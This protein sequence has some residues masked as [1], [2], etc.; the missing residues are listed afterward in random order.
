[1]ITVAGQHLV[2]ERLKLTARDT[3]V[4]RT[5]VYHEFRAREAVRRRRLCEQSIVVR[6]VA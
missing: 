4:T 1:M 5:F 3:Y 6:R 2:I